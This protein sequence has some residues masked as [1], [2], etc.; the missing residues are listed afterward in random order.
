VSEL[1]ITRHYTICCQNCEFRA[2]AWSAGESE[3]KAE[4]HIEDYVEGHGRPNYNHVVS[5]KEET[6]IGRDV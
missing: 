1:N 5:I 3:S 6:L 4:Y 2:E